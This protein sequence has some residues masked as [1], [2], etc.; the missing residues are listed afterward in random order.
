MYGLL[1]SFLATSLINEWPEDMWMEYRPIQYILKR[2][3]GTV[4]SKNNISKQDPT[5]DAGLSAI[6]SNGLHSPSQLNFHFFF[7][8][9]IIIS[10]SHRVLQ[11]GWETR[12]K[13]MIS[14][15]KRQQNEW[16]DEYSDGKMAS[17]QETMFKLVWQWRVGAEYELEYILGVKSE[18]P[19]LSCV[20][21]LIFLNDIE[22]DEDLT[23]MSE[24]IMVIFLK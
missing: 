7:S 2:R 6:E 17:W 1:L 12:K 13:N 24:E 14:A 5:I 21:R 9:I 15:F 3:T 11:D 4:D 20:W 16:M 19:L 10:W 18:W 8:A 22:D 23:G